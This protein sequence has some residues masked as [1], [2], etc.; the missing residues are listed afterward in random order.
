MRCP[1]PPWTVGPPG[2]DE[3]ADVR[4]GPRTLTPGS[5]AGGR[6]LASVTLLHVALASGVAGDE[7]GD[8]RYRLRYTA[9]G[10]SEV[11]VVIE[12]PAPASGP[13]VL[14]MPRAIPMGYGEAP[15]DRFVGDLR[16]FDPD[17]AALAVSREDGPR[18]RLGR[19]AVRVARVE[20][21]VDLRRMER[22]ILAA[23]DAS[24][25]RDGYVSL[26][27]YSVFGYVEGLEGRAITLRI[28]GPAGWP[29]LTTLAPGDVRP[30]PRTAR[31][32]D[33]H[34]LA[35]AQTAMG[36]RLQVRQVAAP[37]PLTVALYAEFESDL[38][39]SSALAAEALRRLVDYFGSIPFSHYTVLQEV[40]APLSPEHR[41]GFSMEH[42]DSA[43]LYLSRE[44]AVTASS[45][46]AD[47]GRVLYNLAHHI[48]HAWIPKR[49]F[50]EGYYPF[51]WEV[52]PVIDTIWFSEGFA[53]YAA[54]VALAEGRPDDGDLARPA[55]RSPVPSGARRCAAVP[56]P[57]VARAALARRIDAI[58]GRLPHGPHDIRARWVDG[59]RDRRARQAAQRRRAVAAGCAAA[60]D[61]V[62]RAFAPPVH[63]GRAAW[64]AGRGCWRGRGGPR[65][66]MAGADGVSLAF[67][68]PWTPDP[69]GPVTYLQGPHLSRQDARPWTATANILRFLVAPG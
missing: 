13:R 36:P 64:P 56:A 8:L 1:S 40:L 24:R 55:R 45:S 11:H 32:S 37:V 12:V 20:Y 59:G 49:C 14:V 17:G 68:S 54:I 48:A 23:S 41:Y 65:R 42:L 28:E 27:G 58:R 16:A 44:G 43:T 35:D 29:V 2:R 15:Y 39:V 19:E 21:V 22:E 52:A 61:W 6:L 33:F 10:A 4:G 51:T 50:G 67:A 18:W 3:S 53:Q 31:A 30:G 69:P 46:E 63:A 34:A 7:A 57:D 62:E 25:V 26:L 47:R 38:T 5:L 60:P 9:P 66:E